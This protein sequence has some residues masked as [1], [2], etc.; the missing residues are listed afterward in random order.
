MCAQPLRNLSRIP[1]CPAC[2]SLPRPLAAEYFCRR[3]GTPF[4]DAFPLDE[5][6]L[7]T[8]CRRSETSF[9]AAYSFGS[10]DG[11]LREL[12]V[13]FK[14]SRVD[15][16]AQPLGRFMLRAMPR[17]QR[18]DMVVPMPMHWFRRW[19]RGFN[20]ADLLARPV[21]RQYGLKLAAPLRRVRLAK[22][23]AGLSASERREN[24]KR[25]F[26][27]RRPADV[28]GKRILLV[29]DVLTTGSTLRA[30]SLALKAAGAKYVAALTLARVVRREPGYDFPAREKR[31]AAT[32]M[33]S[34][35][36]DE[37]RRSVSYA[38][39]RPTP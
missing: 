19:R 1:V 24:L 30:A 33:S 18:F 6:D 12:I 2:L 3:C 32:A 21:A 22:V 15:S 7:C 26:V 29:D 37:Q 17:D 9:D 11:P 27:V 13:L 20:Q 8:V 35:F 23:Q 31:R 38:Q 28:A 10:Y 36:D 5:H 25:A 39:S 16:L 14:Y 34:G 4:V